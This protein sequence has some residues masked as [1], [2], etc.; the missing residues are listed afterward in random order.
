MKKN[1]LAVALLLIVSTL[2][3]LGFNKALATTATQESYD[4]G[5]EA[6]NNNDFTTAFA[7]L[8]PLA[9]QG[10]ASAQFYLGVMYG[11]VAKLLNK[12]MLLLNTV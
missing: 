11:S 6:Y 4:K 8:T 5:L 9:K 10:D 7:I 12:G 3:D 2:I 1:L